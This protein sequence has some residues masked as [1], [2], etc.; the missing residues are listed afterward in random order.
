MQVLHGHLLKMKYQPKLEL[1]KVAAKCSNIHFVTCSNVEKIFG[2]RS[3]LIRGNS[4]RSTLHSTSCHLCAKCKCIYV[5]SKYILQG[6]LLPSLPYHFII[7]IQGLPKYS[8]PCCPVLRYIAI[9]GPCQLQNKTLMFYSQC[10]Y[11]VLFLHRQ[12]PSL[13]LKTILVQS[14]QN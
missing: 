1:S 3:L 14:I 12:N 5:K 2:V 13:P 6:H 8:A 10:M 9:L 7:S 11:S 4:Q